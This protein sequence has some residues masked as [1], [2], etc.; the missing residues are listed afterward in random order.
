MAL[1]LSYSEYKIYS[2]WIMVI[3]MLLLMGIWNYKN[4]TM[5]WERRV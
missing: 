3:I 5:Q 2:L 1:I 4:H